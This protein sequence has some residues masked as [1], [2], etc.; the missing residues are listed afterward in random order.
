MVDVT[1]FRKKGFSSSIQCPRPWHHAPGGGSVLGTV[2]PPSPFSASH[3]RRP[4]PRHRAPG[5]TPSGA[6]FP[7]DCTLDGR[8][9]AA[10]SP[11][12]T[13]T[14]SL[15][16]WGHIKPSSILGPHVEDEAVKSY[17]FRFH[18][19][20]I[21]CVNRFLGASPVKLFA[22]RV[23]SKKKQQLTITRKVVG[24][25]VPIRVLVRVT[26]VSKIF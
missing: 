24:E 21:S 23:F 14:R 19:I 7:V 10:M 12:T 8:V 22:K 2:P 13:H 6:A 20:S 5:T 18:P 3:P 4:R 25:V 16:D 11:A 26:R 9:L 1:I 15:P 17:Y